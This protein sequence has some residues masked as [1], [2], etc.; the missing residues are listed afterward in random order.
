MW[1][2]QTP[3]IVWLRADFH[4]SCLEGR[5]LGFKR[6]EDRDLVEPAALFEE[7]LDELAASHSSLSK[8]KMCAGMWLICWFLHPEL[9]C[10]SLH[11]IGQALT[12]QC[13]EHYFVDSVGKHSFM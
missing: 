3:F 12:S 10:W 7:S 11:N 6:S 4:L 13:L 1:L 5:S 2:R 8:I 9:S